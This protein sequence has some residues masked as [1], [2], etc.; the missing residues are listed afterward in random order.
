MTE[1]MAR[2]YKPSKTGEIIHASFADVNLVIGPVGAGKSSFM[3]VDTV[4]RCLRL[5]VCKDGV[6]RARTGII[7]NTFPNLRMT[8]IKTWLYWFPQDVYGKI[9]WGSPITQRMNF[10]DEHGVQCDFEFMFFSMDKEADQRKLL[11]SEFTFIW[12]NE[13]R[14]I[15]HGH[16]EAACERVGRYPAAHDFPDHV[17]EKLEEQSQRKIKDSLSVA[18]EGDIV[19]TINADTNAPHE[20]HWIVEEFFKKKE[21]HP[22][23]RVVRQPAPLIKQHDGTYIP[24][25]DAENIKNLSKGY[26]YYIDLLNS[27]KP[28]RFRV[29]VMNE[30]GACFDGKAVYEEYYNPILHRASQDMLPISGYPLRLGFDF[31]RTPACVICQFIGGQVRVLEELV[32]ND[33]N[34]PGEL[35]SISVETFIVSF[36]VPILASD[37]YL[38]AGHCDIQSIGDPSGESKKENNDTYCI[39]ILNKNGLNAKPCYTQAPL[40]RIDSLRTYMSRNVGGKSAFIVS[41]SCILIHEGLDGGYH[42]KYYTN[43]STGQKVTGEE[44]EKNKYSHVIE[45]LQYVCAQTLRDAEK[46]PVVKTQSGFWSNGTYVRN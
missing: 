39:Q 37:K 43:A 9:N 34:D 21:K 13:L 28:E 41:P 1:Q 33:E 36:L 17:R 30:F 23:W 26:A 7:R 3:V 38:G 29:M 6:R 14:E 45:A 24:N 35:A 27:S 42:Y 19:F 40:K 20:T 46:K 22:G 18:K 2:V 16:F 10:L 11:G 15:K 12:F 4:L 44:P 32:I 8:T 5:P 31:G 25:P